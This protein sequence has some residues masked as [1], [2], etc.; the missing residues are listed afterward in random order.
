MDTRNSYSIVEVINRSS[1][2]CVV[3]LQKLETSPITLGCGCT[4]MA[5]QT[6]IPSTCPNC[7]KSRCLYRS[8]RHDKVL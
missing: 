3:C 5:H 6:C 2:A 8:K 7:K 1:Y 4:I